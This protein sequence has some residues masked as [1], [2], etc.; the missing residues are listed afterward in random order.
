MVDYEYFLEVLD[1]RFKS[2]T[3]NHASRTVETSFGAAPLRNQR[4]SL[5]DCKLLTSPASEERKKIR[6]T[7]VVGIATPAESLVREKQN[8]AKV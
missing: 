3:L 2:L 7:A 5:G 4:L 6:V 1:K 8:F